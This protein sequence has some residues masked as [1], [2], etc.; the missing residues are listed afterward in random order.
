M[1]RSTAGTCTERRFPLSFLKVSTRSN[2]HGVAGAVAGEV[3]EHE[4]VGIQVVGAGAL[5]Q[6]MKAIAIARG[7]FI[8][9]DDDLVC[10]PEFTEIEID[11]DQRTALLLRVELRS[12]LLARE[13][14]EPPAILNV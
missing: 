13:R 1:A 5:N 12:A 11:G 14:P 4:Q 2:P 3:R 7:F 10:M 8:E 9:R 6:A